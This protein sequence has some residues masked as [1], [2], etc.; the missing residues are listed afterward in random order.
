MASIPDDEERLPSLALDYEEDDSL[1]HD[2]GESA[3]A[4]YDTNA[5]LGKGP[6]TLPCL[7]CVAGTR[8]VGQLYRLE[9]LT[10]IGRA[11]NNGV[12]L[13]EAGVS[14]RHAEV[15]MLPA[16][17]LLVTDLE[18]SNGLY[19]GGERRDNVI[20]EEGDTVQLGD[21]TLSFLLLER[22]EQAE[23]E[24]DQQIDLATGLPNRRAL[25][26]RL[27]EDLDTARSQG[28]PLSLAII[29]LDGLRSVEDVHGETV[30]SKML[31]HVAQR[32]IELVRLEGV[33]VGRTAP[34][35]LTML[36]PHTTL[37]ECTLSAEWIRRTA[38]SQPIDGHKLAL[39]VGATNFPDHEAVDGRAMIRDARAA[40][41]E[42]ILH[43]GS[44]VC[45]APADLSSV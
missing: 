10:T 33:T 18:S 1:P 40:L 4:L 36:L 6:R 11:V 17:R 30:A 29:W 13:T 8:S 5:L 12:I 9:R 24:V 2:E 20:L 31:A 39:S 43:G 41:A 25:M 45:P 37:D 28:R 3:T 32:V 16:G 44:R 42:A 35:E 21:A 27:D 26:R 14:R 38:E 19:V 15:R 34:D 22:I 7:V 23:L